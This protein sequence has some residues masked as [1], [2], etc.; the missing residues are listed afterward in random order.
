MSSISI[1]KPIDITVARN[2]LRK[3]ITGAAWTP[4]A[5]ARAAAALTVFAE[6]ILNANTAGT[7]STSVIKHAG[8]SGI[9]LRCSV[10]AP[11]NCQTLMAEARNRL[12]L[13]TDEL[14]TAMQGDYMI[15]D[16]MIWTNRGNSQ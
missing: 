16:A 4:N 6:L 3:Q 2:F 5:R 14:T 11:E 13:V 1:R 8:G 7:L 10:R 9:K 12:T 15:I